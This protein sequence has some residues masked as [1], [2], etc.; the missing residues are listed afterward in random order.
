MRSRHFRISFAIQIF[1]AIVAIVAMV[2]GVTFISQYQPGGSEVVPPPPPPTTAGSEKELNFPLTKVE[3]DYPWVGDFEMNTKGYH[4]FWFTNGN[5]VPVE[6]GLKTKGCK[7][8]EVQVC[9]FPPK[10]AEKYQRSAPRAAVSQITAAQRGLLALFYQLNLENGETAGWDGPKLEWQMLDVSEKKGITVPAKYAG[11]VRLNWKVQEDKLGKQILNAEL[12]T[13]PQESGTSPRAKVILEVPL[14]FIPI[15]QLTSPTLELGELHTRG[16]K[17]VEFACWSSTRAWFD[18]KGQE[19]EGDQRFTCTCTPLTHEECERLAKQLQARV[20]CGYRVRVTVRERLADTEQ[21]DLGPFTSKI[22]LT[23]DPDI[24]SGGVLVKGVVRGEITVDAVEGKVNLGTFSVRKGVEK[25]VL[26]TAERRLSELKYLRVEPDS[27]GYFQV[28]LKP[29]NAAADGS[30]TQWNL[31]VKVPRG[32]PAGKIP[33]HGAI[34][35]EL[36][37]RGNPPRL[38]RIPVTGTAYQ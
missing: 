2:A 19:K 15:I 20:L 23:S 18:L 6:L 35:L 26:L 8:S 32:S 10:D 37:I 30:G 36:K 38:I 27:L 33:E 17:S 31:T 14:R 11:I 3:W 9:L 29:V 4:D 16:E 25:T 28:K 7:C 1:L 13:Q 24:P 34:V 5:D 21:M 22:V 12:W